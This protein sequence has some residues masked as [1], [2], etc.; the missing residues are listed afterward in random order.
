M[1]RRGFVR[2]RIVS[3]VMLFGAGVTTVLAIVPLISTLAFVIG[4]GLPALNLDLFTQLPAPV[5]EPGGGIA[6]S[7]VGSF[8]VLGLAALIG[9]PVGVGAGVY[10]AEFGQNRLG[11]VIRFMSDVL[12]G[13]PSIIVGIFVYVMIVVTMRSFSALAGGAA[14]AVIMIPVIARTTEEM[15]RLVPMSLREAG[16][17]LGVPYWRV[18]MDIVLRSARG[19][20]ITGVMLSVARAA[21]ETAP[22]LFTAGISAY[23]PSGLVE[24]IDTM[25]VRIFTYAVSPY[26]DWHAKAWAGALVLVS[27]VLLLS[28]LARLFTRGRIVVWRR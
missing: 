10:L 16:L 5:G 14:L 28:I 3:F 2:R 13:I 7:I 6:Q 9:V 12:T 4:K 1:N 21:G 24:P 22:L 23:W 8:I 20:I 26:D 27:L 15:V 11:G 25:P 19:G 17:A 18:V